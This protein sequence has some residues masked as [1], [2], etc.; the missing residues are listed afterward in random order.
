MTSQT[1]THAPAPA[2][3]QAQAPNYSVQPSYYSSYAS[4]SAVD[5]QTL[6]PDHVHAEADADAAVD[7]L[8]DPNDSWGQGQGQGQGPPPRPAVYASIPHTMSQPTSDGWPSVSPGAQT[9]SSQSSTY[10]CSNPPN[11]TTGGSSSSWASA[12][13]AQTAS[14][15]SF[16]YSSYPHPLN[17]TSNN[18][19][20]PVHT[21]SSQSASYSSNHSAWDSQS[22]QTPSSRPRPTTYYYSYSAHQQQQ[23]TLPHDH[24]NSTWPT[25]DQYSS[26]TQTLLPDQS[27]VWG[28][29]DPVKDGQSLIE[30]GTGTGT[31][32]ASKNSSFYDASPSASPWSAPNSAP[33][34]SSSSYFNSW[35][36]PPYYTINKSDQSQQLMQQQPLNTS[37][38][39]PSS[40]PSAAS[41]S[42]GV[43]TGAPPNPNPNPTTH[44]QQQQQQHA[45]YQGQGYGSYSNPTPWGSGWGHSNPEF[46]N[47]QTSR[48]VDRTASSYVNFNSATNTNTAINISDRPPGF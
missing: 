8:L 1:Y 48:P 43:N 20:T 31:W 27:G 18:W 39:W 2:L 33:S 46:A 9:P 47:T 38:G 19:A 32:G 45:K 22:A 28:V 34:S 5:L 44:V 21:A 16:T 26:D 7:L 40:S 35:S 6:L 13:P 25:N 11:Q 30:S 17:Q 24:T 41:K 42:G 4:A 12:S 15:Q 37:D 10:Y 29:S 3:A 36:L 23:Q 14:S